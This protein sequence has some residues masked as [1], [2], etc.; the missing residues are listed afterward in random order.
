MY[1]HIINKSL[2]KSF[3][4]KIQIKDYTKV[5]I[6]FGGLGSGSSSGA[7]AVMRVSEE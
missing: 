5:V 7:N 1:T 3:Y 4:Y 6:K 2:S